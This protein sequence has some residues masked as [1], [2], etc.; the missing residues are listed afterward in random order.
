M[1]FNENHMIS[2]SNYEEW[3][4]LY[5]DNELDA[6]QKTMVDHFLLSHPHL[7]DELHTLLST[8]LPAEDVFYSGKEDLQAAAMKLN[9][10][11]ESLLLLIDN[12]LP[13]AEKKAVLEKIETDN[14]FRLQH[15]MLLQTK[16]DA[17]EIISYP[18]KNELYR[19]TEKITPFIPVWM[20]IAVAV[21]LILFTALF[22]YNAGNNQVT[23]GYDVA[24]KTEKAP[25]QNK[26]RL[27]VANPAESSQPGAQ[28]AMARKAGT[29]PG[30]IPAI[31]QAVLAK[32]DLPKKTTMQQEEPVALTAIETDGIE[33][34][35]RLQIDVAKL[36]LPPVTALN[37][38]MANLP[39]TSATPASYNLSD[40]PEE[41]IVTD[42]DDKPKRT[43][44]KGFFRK[45]SRFIE[46][47]T[48][49]G[50]VNADNELLI[51]AVALKLN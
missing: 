19:R 4:I 31:K 24:V 30:K 16:L 35:E 34:A 21:M 13:A 25:E 15:S 22:F 37:N 38:S 36:N 27:P 7:M 18:D 5:M 29:P 8:K 47:R 42:G 50:T 10:V 26:M 17:A 39:V 40:N 49:I 20:R 33:R 14:D 12:E 51:G 9:M 44:A 46:R 43:P 1:S 6:A 28:P 32:A 3:F 41:A 45:V 23:P 48:G 11:D 2:L